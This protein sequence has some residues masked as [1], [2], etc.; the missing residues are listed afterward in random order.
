MKN[1]SSM[2]KN[3]VLI[4][5][6]LT[7]FVT[8]TSAFVPLWGHF[9]ERLGGND[10]KAV[11]IAV[12]L[13]YASSGLFNFIFSFLE[14]KHKKYYLYVF[15]SLVI[16]TIG[17]LLFS[18]VDSIKSLYFV[19]ILLGL[20]SGIMWPAF[21]TIFQNTMLKNKEALSWGLYGAFES[22]SGALGAIIGS[23][24]VHYFDYTVLFYTLAILNFVALI[25]TYTLFKSHP[26]NEKIL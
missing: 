15:L 10:L 18:Y 6:V 5:L 11:G 13:N 12:S 19:I 21:D 24:I 4:L 8:T 25:F 16:S 23:H 3:F 20:G 7:F 9:I 17:W 1:F 26:L 22:L 14:D 2:Y